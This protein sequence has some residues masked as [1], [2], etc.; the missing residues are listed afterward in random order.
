MKAIVLRELGGP[1]KLLL[2]EMPDPAPGPGEVVI[3]LKTAAMNHRDVWIRLGKYAGITLPVIL[4]SDGAGEI[5][6]IGLGVDASLAGKQ[7]IINPSFEWGNDPRAQGPNFRILG[8][9]DPG[10]YA[11]YVKIPAANVYPKPAQLS[12]EEAAALPVAATTAYRAVVTRGQVKK[13]E[14]VVVVGI[15]GGVAA[16][17]LQMAIRLGARVFVTS[18]SHEKIQRA[19]EL[20]AEGGVNYRSPDWVKELRALIGGTGPDVVFDSAGGET[21]DQTLDLVRPGGRVVT[22]GATLGPTKELAVRRIFWKQLTILGSTM[23]KQQDFEQAIELYGSGGL[24][25]VIDKVFPLTDV[26]SAHKRMDEAGQFGKI[27]LTISP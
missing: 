19:Q 2:E 26:Q 8:L 20:G 6:A 16:F 27:V 15:G 24:R 17:I 3:R 21:F 1:E 18:G 5:S 11:E 7:V 12:W 22:F 23:G 13:G 14:T 10:T 4:G 9:Q 25:P